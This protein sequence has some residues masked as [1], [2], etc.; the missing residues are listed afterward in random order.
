MV[1]LPL[2]TKRSVT[3]RG[4]SGVCSTS[5]S[6]HPST[7]RRGPLGRVRAPKRQGAPETPTPTRT[8][9]HASSQARGRDE[10]GHQMSTSTSARRSLRVLLLA[11]AV[12]S[13]TA[14]C[15]RVFGTS[16][17]GAWEGSFQ[18]ASGGTGI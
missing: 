5:C 13:F 18:S 10:Q 4:P 7:L 3:V 2:S 12:V 17:S 15:D 16:L 1:I 11:A 14:G 8:A 9:L 6:A